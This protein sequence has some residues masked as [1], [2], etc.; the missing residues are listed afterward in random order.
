[1]KSITAALALFLL[2]GAGCSGPPDSPAP[3]TGPG[4]TR[5]VGALAFSP[6]GRWLASAGGDGTIR[7]WHV[8]TGREARVITVA[9][10]TIGGLAWSPDGRVVAAGSGDRI[11]RLFD[12]ES[13]A[14][15]RAL[16]GH[17]REV[18]RLHFSSDGER[19]IS[20]DAQGGVKVWRWRDGTLLSEI[21]AQPVGRH[22]A[23]L[24]ISDDGRRV[25]A[26]EYQ[27]GLF[28]LDTA[29]GTLAASA[30]G[31]ESQALSQT[32]FAA[33]SADGREI[34]VGLASREL[35]VWDS[36]R[37]RLHLVPPARA[38]ANRFLWQI[39][40][41][42]NGKWLLTNDQRQLDLVELST[43]RILH[44]VMNMPG[45]A[46]PAIL[47]ADGTLVAMSTPLYTIELVELETGRVARRL[48]TPRYSE[49]IED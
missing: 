14:E 6:D 27:R 31:D 42:P 3:P 12:A 47:S 46:Y 24:A 8:D 23:I 36:D 30:E 48:G 22:R 28:L 13:G 35:A 32:R 37:K 1:M 33:F 49:P 44:T 38:D 43:G 16:T 25:A 17:I 40:V 34:I 39:L 20:A 9:G 29:S 21:K 4:H 2:V 15:L 11:V 45:G 26:T 18:R 7:I 41:H 5:H 19:L 10:Q